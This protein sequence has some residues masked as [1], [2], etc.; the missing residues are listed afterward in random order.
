MS[1]KVLAEA[2]AKADW[3]GAVDWYE[4]REPGTGLRFD[5][6]LRNFLQS[7]SRNPER[8]PRP[9]RLTRKARMPGPWP[10]SACLTVNREH[11]EVKMLAIWRGAR[12]PAVLRQR[13]R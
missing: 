7:L 10:Y 2:E 1:F 11:H 4:E 9:G 13:L 6:A 3:N 8:F 5:D 12:N